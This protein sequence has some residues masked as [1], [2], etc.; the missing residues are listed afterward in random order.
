VL[1]LDPR[2]IVIQ[3]LEALY[4]GP[5]AKTCICYVYFRY[6]DHSEMT[7]RNILETLVM[8]TL[9]RHPGCQG[10]I[11]QTYAR[12]LRE[13][14]QPAEAQ[15]LSLLRELVGMMTCTFYI[16]DALDEAPTR[17][18]L[19]ILKAVASLNVKI[20]ITSR[21]LETLQAHFPQAFT[22]TIAAQDADLDLHI[23]QGIE[24]QVE[25]QR[26]LKANP[27]LRDEIFAVIKQNCGGMYAIHEFDTVLGS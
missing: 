11:E 8:Q 5:D 4:P 12:H 25:L 17:I 3:H 16:L 19:A 18:Q 27:V 7:V 10:R 26:L 1:T 15:L 14:T 21:P 23:T 20:F 22:F 13:Q 6:S 2:S 24:E 9:E